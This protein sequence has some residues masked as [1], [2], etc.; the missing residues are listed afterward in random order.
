M[1]V[2]PLLIMGL[3]YWLIAARLWRG[4][5][6]ETSSSVNTNT[7]SRLQT[8]MAAAESSAP[9]ENICG[10][11]CTGNDIKD[12]K[13]HSFVSPILLSKKNMLADTNEEKSLWLMRKS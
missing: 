12:E 9:L 10:S 4:L 11:S 5:R 1:L 13:Y 8:M 3:A 7:G 6:H 2:L